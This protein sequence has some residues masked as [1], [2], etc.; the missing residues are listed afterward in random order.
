MNTPANTSTLD[1]FLVAV[2]FVWGYTV[3]SHNTKTGVDVKVQKI[4]F[5]QIIVLTVL[6]VLAPP[7]FAQ[8]GS[9]SALTGRVTDP[10]RA[11]LPGVMVTAISTA[12]NQ[13]RST[14]T[15]E[16]GVYRIP[17]LDPGV[18]KVRFMLPGFKA[19]EVTDITLTVT[20]TTVVNRTLE[21][22]GNRQ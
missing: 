21:D 5:A 16:D 10:T 11:V 13:Q 7:V 12:T 4:L 1:I 18:Y 14:V 9:T 15:A 22:G 3:P 2:G 8:T 19:A 6:V 17:L 20:E